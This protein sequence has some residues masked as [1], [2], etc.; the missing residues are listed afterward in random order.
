MLDTGSDVSILPETVYAKFFPK[1]ALWKPSYRLK[2]YG[3]NEI[4]VLGCLK[5]TVA[6]GDCGTATD[7]YIAKQGSAVLG[8]DLITALQMQVING[9]VAAASAVPSQAK[10]QNVNADVNTLGCAKGFIHRVKVRPDIQPVQ[11]KL[12]RL[13]FAVR[14]AVSKELNKLVQ[15]DVIEPVESSEW[16]SPIVVTTKKGGQCLRLCVD[17]REPNKSVVV[18]GFPCRTWRK[19]LLSSEGQ[20]CFPH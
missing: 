18:D 8:R 10:V 13:P 11:L 9:Q 15:Q 7:L 17:L 3:G 19:C 14:E 12:R 20:H 16:I 1:A 2:D 4:T 6:F 5:A